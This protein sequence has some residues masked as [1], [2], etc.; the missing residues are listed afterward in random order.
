VHNGH[1]ATMTVNC[2]SPLSGHLQPNSPPILAR[3]IG[4]LLRDEVTIK[5]DDGNLGEFHEFCHGN[6]DPDTTCCADQVSGLKNLDIVTDV[7]IGAF[8]DES[9]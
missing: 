6:A 5:D 3:I 7:G 4:R 2:I 1:V 9:V 8:N